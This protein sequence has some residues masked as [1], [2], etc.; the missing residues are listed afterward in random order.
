MEKLNINKEIERLICVYGN[1]VLRTSYLYL[2]DMQ[3]AEDAFQEVFIKAYKNYN[4][5]KGKSTEK[6]WILSITINLCK[7][8]LRS[9]WLRRVFV[10]DMPVTE[11]KYQIDTDKAAITLIENKLIFDEVMALPSVLK[12]V[13]ILYYYHQFDTKEISK[14]L[15]I[16]EGTVRSRLHRAREILRDKLKGRVEHFE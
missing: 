2:K 9:S 4:S 16:A 3:R 10:S 12:D 7:D 14:I 13:V 15:G 1:D 5:F 8:T 6:T 11:E